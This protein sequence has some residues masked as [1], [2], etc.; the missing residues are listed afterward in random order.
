MLVA[1]G[2][3]GGHLSIDM[4]FVS[5]DQSNSSLIASTTSCPQDRSI[6]VWTRVEAGGDFVCVGLGTGHAE[7]VGTVTLS[8][9]N[10]FIISGSKDTTV[11]LWE[12][13]PLE[14]W[15]GGDPVSLV[16]RYTRKAHD[17]GDVT[18]V[19]FPVLWSPSRGAHCLSW[20]L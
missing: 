3:V 7:A 12:L 18:G 11:K 16:S 9:R 10:Q 8:H 4:V 1:L 15:S 5:S 19:A 2:G 13:A 6:R 17:K 20:S 14:Q